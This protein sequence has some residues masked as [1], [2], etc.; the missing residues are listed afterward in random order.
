M[1]LINVNDLPETNVDW[2]ANGEPISDTV[3]NRPTKQVAEHVNTLINEV[4]TLRAN[5]SDES[6]I[7]ALLFGGE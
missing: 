4:D 6:F 2:I 1:E 7:N 3:L 5:A